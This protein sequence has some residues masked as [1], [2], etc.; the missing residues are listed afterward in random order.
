MRVQVRTN[1]KI[2]P[3]GKDDNGFEKNA[4]TWNMGNSNWVALCTFKDEGAD[5]ATGHSIK[6]RDWLAHPLVD[7]MMQDPDMIAH[8]HFVNKKNQRISADEAIMINDK[9]GER[10]SRACRQATQDIE[11][12]RRA[13]V[14]LNARLKLFGL[15]AR[16]MPCTDITKAV[17]KTMSGPKRSFAVIKKEPSSEEGTLCMCI[18][19]FSQ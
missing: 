9:F 4:L 2:V 12:Q 15:P 14:E 6:L 17:N 1:F 11:R 7:I 16:V 10:Y 13:H 3:C 8:V 19:S 18:R 5:Q